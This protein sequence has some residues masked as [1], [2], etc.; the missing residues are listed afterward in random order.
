MCQAVPSAHHP[1]A[2]DLSP[3]RNWVGPL[4]PYR[5]KSKAQGRKTTWP[6]SHCCCVGWHQ[7]HVQTAWPP[8]TSCLFGEQLQPQS[9]ASFPRRFDSLLF[10]TGDRG[11]LCVHL[12]TLAAPPTG[13]L[14]S[15]ELT[16]LRGAH[17]VLT[18]AG[19]N[20]RGEGCITK[21]QVLTVNSVEVQRRQGSG[22]P[23]LPVGSGAPAGLGRQGWFK[24]ICDVVFLPFIYIVMCCFSP[25]IF[26]IV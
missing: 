24:F 18:L 9:F 19:G 4:C 20:L 5:W 14:T 12:C 15:G 16:H 22:C 6:R 13:S 23:R 3:R 2:S 21:R 7:D 11:L 25:F 8:G 10:R 26:S 17:Y 1:A